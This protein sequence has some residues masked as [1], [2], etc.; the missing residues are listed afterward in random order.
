MGLEEIKLFEFELFP[1]FDFVFGVGHMPERFPSIFLMAVAY[2][3]DKKVGFSVDH[4]FIDNLLYFE[5]LTVG[6]IKH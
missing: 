3:L 5:F 2:P 6:L 4:F 1:V